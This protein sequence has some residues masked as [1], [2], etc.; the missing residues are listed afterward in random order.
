MRLVFIETTLFTATA[1]GVLDDK[2]LRTVQQT[3]LDDPYAGA[4][5]RGTDGARKVRVA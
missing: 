4:T 3:L 1:K 5:E 2:A